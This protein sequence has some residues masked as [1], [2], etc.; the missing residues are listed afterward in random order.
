MF[1]TLKLQNRRLLYFLVKS[2]LFFHV[3][4][5]LSKSDH[6]ERTLLQASEHVV[7]TRLF[8]GDRSLLSVSLDIQLHAWLQHLL[9]GGD[10]LLI[11][12][13]DAVPV[14]LLVGFFLR[15]VA[16]DRKRVQDEFG[17]VLQFLEVDVAHSTQQLHTGEQSPHS[18]R[19]K[20]SN[21][22]EH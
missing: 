14:G 10:L 7:G 20:R 19:G 2:L 17:T 11:E 6:I 21:G 3:F 1:I 12:Y 15:V 8:I 9:K 5:S 18:G 16:I 13:G 4:L 22:G